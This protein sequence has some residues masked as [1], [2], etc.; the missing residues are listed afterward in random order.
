MNLAIRDRAREREGSRYINIDMGASTIIVYVQFLLNPVEC[1]YPP[2]IYNLFFRSSKV[3][4]IDHRYWAY[5]D[6]NKR[7]CKCLIWLMKTSHLT[8]PWVNLSRQDMEER[9]M[10][11]TQCNHSTEL[12]K[13][14]CSNLSITMWQTLHGP[15]AATRNTMGNYWLTVDCSFWFITFHK[16]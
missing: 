15:L 7:Q 3:I 5:L 13:C 16:W 12:Y 9:T 11:L 4:M 8:H 10:P 14:K 1:S 2:K 6:A